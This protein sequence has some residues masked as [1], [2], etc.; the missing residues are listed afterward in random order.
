MQPFDSSRE[1]RNENKYVRTNSFNMSV[2]K[3][4]E[5]SPI[6]IALEGSVNDESEAHTLKQEEVDEQMRN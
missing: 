3:S 6:L 1:L 4:S 2:N 5:S